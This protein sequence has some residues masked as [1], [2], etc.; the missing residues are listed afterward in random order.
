MADQVTPYNYYRVGDLKVL[1]GPRGEVLYVVTGLRL[2]SGDLPVFH[3]STG[4]SCHTKLTPY[5]VA[6]SLTIAR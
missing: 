4:V 2:A 6:V 5:G 3:M 1:C